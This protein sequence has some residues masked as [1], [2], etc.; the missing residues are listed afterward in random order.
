M[1]TVAKLA[2]PVE[3][4]AIFCQR[5]RIVEFALFGSVLEERFSAVSDLDIA[6]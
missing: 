1:E 5:W 4:I 3:Q 6:E 2:I